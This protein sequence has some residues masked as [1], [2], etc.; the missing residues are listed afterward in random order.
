VRK[1]LDGEGDYHGVIGSSKA[2]S[3]VFTLI[4]RVKDLNVPVVFIGE[5][6]TGKDLLA[7]VLH[8]QSQLNNGPFVVANCGSVPETLVESTLFGHAKGAFSGAESER[9]GL[10]QASDGGTLY[11]DELG[12]I[13]PRMQVD[14]L[15]VLQEGSFS[16]LGSS[17]TISIN[18]RI[19]ASSRLPLDK[20]V[21]QG[22]LRKDLLYRL[23][24]VTIVLPPLRHRKDDILLLAR[25]ILDREEKRFNQPRRTLSRKA[26]TALLAHK[27]PGNV[28]ELEQ[29]LR[30]T[31]AVGEGTGQIEP[32]ELFVTSS[33]P[34]KPT[35][36][37]PPKGYTTDAL[38]DEEARIIEALERHKWNRT[39]A[40]EELGI[41]RRTFYRKIDKMGLVKK[42][43][44]RK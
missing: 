12:D 42:R 31:I 24:V 35:T 32:E 6:G 23:E 8:E 43:G 17:E 10:L 39:K 36:A 44:Y 4:E 27:W 40:A 21:E 5:S 30:R 1:Q 14:L 16:P 37:L 15:R 3:K 28:R 33:P 7:R 38:G 9:P 26:A 20:L 34:P 25:R 13:S 41:P 19:I 18:T 29:V 22:G 2:M 11:L